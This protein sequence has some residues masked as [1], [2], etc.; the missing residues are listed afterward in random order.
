MTTGEITPWPER[1]LHFIGIGGAGM[2]GLAH[3]AHR[4]GATVTGS[5]RAESAYLDRL[6]ADD[7]E[8]SIGHDA[9]NLPEGAEVVVSTAIGDENPELSL[10]RE[11]GL[12]VLHRS[13]LLA[14]LCASRRTIAIA[15]THGKTSTTGMVVH[16][17]RRL[18]RDPSYFVGGELPAATPG[19]DPTNSEWGGGDW[20]V[21]EADESDG[22]FLTLAPEI[23]VITN[24]EM[25]HHARWS[26]L[27]ELRAAFLD[28]GAR[29]RVVV[30]PESDPGLAAAIGAGA[31][32]VLPFGPDSPGPDRLELT[33]PGEHNLLNARAAL[34]AMI[35]AGIDPDE[36]ADALASFPGVR[37]RLEFKGEAGGSRIYDDYAHHPTEVR[38]AL[39]ALRG[40]EPERLIAIFQPH[41]Y[42]RTRIFSQEFGAALAVADELIVLDVYPAREQPV[43]SLAGVSGLD[44]VREAA[45]RSGGRPVWWAPDLDSAE[46]AARSRIAPGRVLVTLG[47]GDVTSLSDR[48]ADG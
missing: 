7:L 23:A 10:A 41:L 20:V 12:S 16:A 2:S 47:A 17:L 27:A 37:R 18:G 3:V 40:L 11:R 45:S 29:S 34:A 31:A 15:G 4:L 14:E 48:L 33:V 19:G 5:D 35:A 42:S 26:N 46:R 8:I 38:A 6:R 25:D 13:A 1:R 32:T 22:S 43:G 36:A 9:A 44:V 24:I 28:F 39:T 30:L 21:V